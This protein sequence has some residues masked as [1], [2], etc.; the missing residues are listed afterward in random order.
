MKLSLC[1]PVYNG[2]RLLQYTLDSIAAQTRLP[3]ELIIT[4]NGSTDTSGDIID[5]FVKNHCSLRTRIIV[6]DRPSG[7][8]SDWNLTVAEAEGD[9]VMLLPADDILL[10]FSLE[11]HEKTWRAASCDIGFSFGPK[12]IITSSGRTLPFHLSKFKSGKIISQCDG[13][14]IIRSPRNP[15]GEPGAVVFSRK[16]F[17]AT[18]GFDAS[19]SY[20]PDLDLWLKFLAMSNGVC[21][22]RANYAFRIS[23]GSLTHVN[24]KLAFSEWNKL[25]IRHAPGLGLSANPDAIIRA[26]GHMLCFCRTIAVRLF[27]HI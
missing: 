7:M 19:F 16:L 18:G 4:N 14:Q 25:Y 23:K 26:R 3:D 5:A 21:V 9:L 8:V 22:A 17:L 27:N 6:R 13:R 12:Y 1:V 11:E 2:G 15:I 24:Q 20:Y 10:P